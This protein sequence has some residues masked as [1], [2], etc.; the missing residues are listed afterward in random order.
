MGSVFKKTYTK[1]L[2][3]GAETYMRGERRHARWKDKS[4]KTRTAVL[5]SGRDGADRIRLKAATYTGKFRDGTG[6]VV[7]KATGCSDKGAALAVLRDFE[8]RAY[9]VRANV[10]SGAEDAVIDHQ[11]SP[12]DDHIDAYLEYLRGK[13]TSAK[14]RKGV[15]ANLR[16]I[17][18]ESGFGRLRDLDRAAFERWL[19]ARNDDGMGARTRNAYREAVVAFGNWCV[20]D[21]RLLANP[22]EGIP[23]ANQR[24]DARRPRRALTE[25]E[26]GELLDAALRRPLIDAMTIRRGPRKGEQGCELR[27]ESLRRYELLGVERMLIYKTL[28]LT[29]LRKG[30]LASIT[31]GQVILDDPRPHIVLEAADAKNAQSAHIPL[32]TDL[33]ED[34]D[35]W[36]RLK[37]E[38]TRE[39]AL[40]RGEPSAARL[41]G[42]TP[43]FDV[44]QDLVKVLDRD[45]RFA[46][47]AKKDERGRTVD[48]HSLR[49]TFGTLLTKA[50]A[51]PRVVQ[52]LMRHSD[53]RLTAN[54]YTDLAQ[55]DYHGA[56][57][58]LPTFGY[59][60]EE[61]GEHA[62]AAN[63]QPRT[64]APML[65]PNP[66]ASCISES[67]PDKAHRR[68]VKESG[69]V[70]TAISASTDT[71]CQPVSSG[72]QDKEMAYPQGFEPRTFWSVAR[73][74]IQLSYGYA[75]KRSMK[76]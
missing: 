20:R 27:P 32:R 30:E 45:L 36:L 70:P 61:Q 43:L 26:V 42:S 1:P 11:N 28:A 59:D 66:G 65:A 19:L 60:H 15:N 58:S 41:E 13:D 71:T 54:V 4:G 9:K 35:V 10:L 29:G 3:E 53:P 34:L 51:H 68:K 44:P 47:I 74:S 31:V 8:V 62:A 76:S 67:S 75:L 52:A 64:L 50:G 21:G 55:L 24:A 16:R 7:E 69:S 48:V 18:S 73:C 38:S 56:V 22:F 46:G 5:T 39:D 33:A 63:D 57:G 40:R 14:H 17:A 37:R 23:K 25:A 49:H 6:C 12:L 2:P 72:G